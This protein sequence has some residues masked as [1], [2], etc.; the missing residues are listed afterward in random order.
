MKNKGN[1]MKYEENHFNLPCKTKMSVNPLVIWD[2]IQNK[3]KFLI[4]QVNI[5]VILINT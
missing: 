4:Y 3:L 5:N 1:S 2:K